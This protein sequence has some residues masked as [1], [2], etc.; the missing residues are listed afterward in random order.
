MPAG[1]TQPTP[2]STPLKGSRASSRVGT[3]AATPSRS[4]PA[5]TPE[6]TPAGEPGSGMRNSRKGTRTPGPIKVSQR[7]DFEEGQES[8]IST[9]I[10]AAVAVA[11]VAVVGIGAW[12]GL[13]RSSNRK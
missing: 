9:G 4:T 1:M 10:I 2:T 12:F 11:A 6:S 7:L 5:A 8:T 13:R 3:P